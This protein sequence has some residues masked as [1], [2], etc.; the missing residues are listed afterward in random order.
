MGWHQSKWTSIGVVLQFRGL[1][2]LA[3]HS[4]RKIEMWKSFCS[5][6]AAGYGVGKKMASCRVLFAL[7]LEIA[8]VH[9]ERMHNCTKVQI[10]CD[11]I[12]EQVYGCKDFRV[13]VVGGK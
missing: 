6:I 3:V 7:H 12:A 10:H 4:N 5:A 9:T 13:G 2:A 8:R 1:I 11:A